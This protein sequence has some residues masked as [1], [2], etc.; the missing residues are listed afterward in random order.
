VI[1]RRRVITSEEQDVHT[2]WRHFLCYLHRAGAKA[3]VKR[4]T[5][6]RERREGKHE[7][8]KQSDEQ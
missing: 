3:A 8:R 7:V 6:R 1:Q 5:N 2:R 4:R